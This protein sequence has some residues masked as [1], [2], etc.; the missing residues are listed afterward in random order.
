MKYSFL[1]SGGVVMIAIMADMLDYVLSEEHTV[2]NG[3]HS[4]PHYAFRCKAYK[5]GSPL[6][7]GQYVRFNPPQHVKD[8]AHELYPDLPLN[9][10][11]IKQV[12]S[13]HQ[14]L[15]FVLGTHPESFDSRQWGP[16]FIDEIN[17][18]C[19]GIPE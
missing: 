19:T 8:I 12:H 10:S 13:I 4:L 11:W 14:D 16:L 18:V 17:E 9:I 7:P 2:I 3:S 1:I 5:K 6:F 15:V